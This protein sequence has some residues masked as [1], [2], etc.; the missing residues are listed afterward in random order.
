V[1]NVV[2]RSGDVDQDGQIVDELPREEVLVRLY[3]IL[4]AFDRSERL[5]GAVCPL[6][7]ADA[8]SGLSRP[9]RLRY[10]C[11]RGRRAAGAPA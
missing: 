6:S 4:E 11:C 2:D 8:A 9:H 7:E 3:S 1:E 10:G 5:S